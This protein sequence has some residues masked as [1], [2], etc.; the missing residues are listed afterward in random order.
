MKNIPE[1]TGQKPRRSDQK[2][3]YSC[4]KVLHYS[5]SSCPSCGALQKEQSNNQILLADTS[6]SRGIIQAAYCRGCGISIH[7]SAVS[8]PKCGARQKISGSGG[9]KNHVTAGLL[10]LLLGGIGV[11]KFYCGKTGWGVVYLLFCWTWIPM[12]VGFIE[13][14]LYFLCDS[15]VEFTEKYC[16]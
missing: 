1:T 15:D 9:I 14:I 10:A 12:I 5:A 3:C 2:F 7:I 16:S 11:H 6:G 4:S 13:S 8:C